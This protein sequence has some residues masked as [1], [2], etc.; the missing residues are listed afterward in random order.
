MDP[1]SKRL[2]KQRERSSLHA[3]QLNKNAL[4]M[5][6]RQLHVLERHQQQTARSLL[7]TRQSILLE[8]S[9]TEQP[10]HEEVGKVRQD[11]PRTPPS[12]PPVGAGPP[13]AAVSPNVAVSLPSGMEHSPGQSH[14]VAGVDLAL[15]RNWQRIP[16]SSVQGD[17]QNGSRLSPTIGGPAAGT[18]TSVHICRFK[19]LSFYSPC[20]YFPCARPLSYHHLRVSDVSGPVP[21]SLTQSEATATKGPFNSLHSASWPTLSDS[22]F[23]STG[24]AV[25]TG[26]G[27]ATDGHVSP[28]T[29]VNERL[30]GLRQ[31]VREL[32][33]KNEEKRPRAWA[34]NYGEPVSRR[35]LRKPAVPVSDEQL[36][37]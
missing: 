4:A 7:R 10:Q 14:P 27:R 20:R 11:T 5:L 33:E 1:F 15:T 29:S 6:H 19:A 34:V 25:Q 32:R 13:H 12:L 17:P 21:F 16:L 8:L 37:Q 26:G 35:L 31:L 30:R 22:I 24:S 2:R 9:Q 23:S 36:S 28:R 18:D 3:R